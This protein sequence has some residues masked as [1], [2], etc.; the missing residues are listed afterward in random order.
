MKNG[1]LSKFPAIVTHRQC[2]NFVISTIVAHDADVS[3]CV[4]VFSSYHFYC[5]HFYCKLCFALRHPGIDCDVFVPIDM[6]LCHV[7]TFIHLYAGKVGLSLL[8][9]DIYCGHMVKVRPFRACI[10]DN[11][12]WTYAYTHILLYR[13]MHIYLQ[14]KLCCLDCNL[15][16]CSRKALNQRCSIVLVILARVGRPCKHRLSGRLNFHTARTV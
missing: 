7:H 4:P 11:M 16:T 6:I 9:V 1:I 14:G 2:C 5:H 13:Y 8:H 3:L 10:F 12:S 15:H